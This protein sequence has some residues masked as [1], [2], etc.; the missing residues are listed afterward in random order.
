MKKSFLL[1]SFTFLSFFYSQA[2]YVPK[3]E[4]ILQPE[5]NIE[6]V[7]KCADFWINSQAFDEVNGGFFSNVGVDGSVSDYQTKALLAQTRHA[8]GFT[9][10]FMLTGDENYLTYANSALNFLYNYGWDNT[11]GGWFYSTNRTG[12]LYALN[13]WWD[14]NT[15]KWGFQQH[16]ALVGIVAHYEATHNATTESWMEKG[17][18]ELNTKMWD[19]RPGYEG[20]YDEGNLN[21]SNKKGKGFTPTV[22]AI[23]THGELL[24]LVT[25]KPEYKTRLMDLATIISNKLMPEMSNVKVLYP[26]VFDTNWVPDYTADNSKGSIGHFIKTAWCLGRAFLCDTTKTE[27]KEAATKILDQ[28]WS[29]DQSGSTIWDHEN[30]G[31]FNAMNISTGALIDNS[32]DF[33]T[34]EQGFTGPMINYYIT[35]KPS[36][37]QMADESMTFFMKHQ[38]DWVNGEVFPLISADGLTVEKHT[39]GEDFKSSYHS[40]ELGYYGYLYNSLYYLH[41]P[42]SLYYKFEPTTDPQDISLTPIPI[43]DECL[44]IASVTL[45]GSDFTNFNA[46]TRTLNIGANEGGKFKVTYQYVPKEPNALAQVNKNLIQIYPVPAI[47]TLNFSGITDIDNIRIMDISGK[48]VQ[49]NEGNGHNHQTIDISS[50]NAGIY[51]ITLQNKNGEHLLKKMV[52]L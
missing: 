9:R 16:Y 52:K 38:V 40:I 6:Y 19:S 51:F 5:L 13:Q 3:S 34:V 47:N 4:Y 8:Y 27:Y 43:E 45:N 36:Y 29:Y 50:L 11:Y 26:E 12:E 21:W 10:A 32:K 33:W 41:Q 48:V 24:Y 20:Y 46:K 37:L 14:P 25:K 23:T 2:Q 30:G 17:I 1:L 7:K 15:F 35:K 44:Q 22:D 39:K 28:T 49:Y 42:A 31:P 18:N